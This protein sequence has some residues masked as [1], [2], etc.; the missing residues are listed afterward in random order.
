MAARRAASALGATAHDVLLAD[1]VHDAVR[2]SM[3]GLVERF[4]AEAAEGIDATIRLEIGD[5]APMALH[6]RDGRCLLTRGAATAA[7]A[8][9]VLRTDRSCWL[10]LAA[11]HA[12]GIATFL[13]G[14]L[15]VHGDL[16]LAAR[17]E[18]LFAP[19]PGGQRHLRAT[20]TRIKGTTIDALVAGQGTPVLL[21]HGLGASKVSFLPTLDA[22]SD[23]Y[24]VHALDLPGYGRSSKPL[25]TGRRYSMAWFADVVH[26]YLVA[27]RLGDAHLVGNSM[28]ARI[29]LELALHRPRSVRSVTGLAPAVAFDETRAMAPLLRLLRP[30]WLGLAPTPVPAAVIERIVRDLFHDPARLPAN[31]LQA[32]ALDVVRMSRDPGFRMALIASARHLGADR[33]SGRRGYWTRLAQTI[34]PSLWVFGA[35]DRLVAAHYAGRVREALPAADVQVWE[36]MGHVPQ[37]EDPVRTH[38]TLHRWL[39]RVDAGR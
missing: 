28:G 21:L 22:L 39:A 12:E 18:T 30:Q 25:P 2:L 31:N 15:E 1:D 26:G 37:F 10:D 19:A 7:A 3:V 16:D 38:D 13:H 9:V 5:S 23:R 8:D 33:L 32:A 36:S 34:P 24:E 14:D 11:G 27:N 29:A 6:V 4:Q 20:R 17:F 35:Q